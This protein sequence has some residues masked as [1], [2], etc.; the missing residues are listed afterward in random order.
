MKI[1][2]ENVLIALIIKEMVQQ[3]EFDGKELRGIQRFLE[4]YMRKD[5]IENI[6]E[7]LDID[8]GDRDE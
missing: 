3:E 4:K 8:I 7:N 6:A 2:N 1:Y 5:T